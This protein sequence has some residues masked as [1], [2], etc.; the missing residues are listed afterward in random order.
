MYEM[1]SQKTWN[2]AGQKLTAHKILETASVEQMRAGNWEIVPN[3]KHLD[4]TLIVPTDS[5]NIVVD[6]NGRGTILLETSPMAYK[7]LQEL[8]SELD[9]KWA[10][11]EKAMFDSMP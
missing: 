1:K 8:K 11:E 4:S 5:S 10:A 2:F 9:E 3:I 6:T 7:K